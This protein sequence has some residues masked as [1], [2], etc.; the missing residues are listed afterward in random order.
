MLLRK[1]FFCLLFA[2][3][4]VSNANSQAQAV[5]SSLGKVNLN[6]DLDKNGVPQYSISF[7]GKQVIKPSHL[8]FRLKGGLSLDSNFQIIKIDSSAADETWKPVWVE[9]S[10]V[11]NHYKQTSFYLQQRTSS[12]LLNIIFKIFED[13]VGF[14]YEF[15][16]QSNLSN[17]IVSDELT[18]FNLTE[19][20]SP[21]YRK[22]QT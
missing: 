20:K 12:L 17:F 14:R 11:R 5:S 13:G 9:V 15:P 7:S 1:G 3:V 16:I 18:E 10:Q 22:Y 21:G 8:G 19:S 2:S 4:F 6:F